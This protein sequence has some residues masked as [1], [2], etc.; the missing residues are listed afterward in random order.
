MITFLVRKIWRF[1]FNAFGNKFK[2]SIFHGILARIRREVF[3]HFLIC[4]RILCILGSTLKKYSL[5]EKHRGYLHCKGI[6]F[7]LKPFVC[8]ILPIVVLWNRNLK[9]G[10]I[11]YFRY[12]VVIDFGFRIFIEVLSI[13]GLR[14]PLSLLIWFGWSWIFV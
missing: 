1:R 6:S 7:L 3:G 2:G 4:I 14:R 12:F 8:R 5:N 11:F 10:I 13:L 9:L